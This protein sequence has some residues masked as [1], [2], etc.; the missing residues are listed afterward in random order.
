VGDEISFEPIDAAGFA[1]LEARAAAGEPVA[2]LVA[3]RP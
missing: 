2:R 1:S 3:P